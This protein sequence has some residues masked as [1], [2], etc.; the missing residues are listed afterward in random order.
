MIHIPGFTFPVEEFL[1]EDVVQMTRWAEIQQK[2]AAFKH[3]FS[4]NINRKGCVHLGIVLRRRTKGPGGKKAFG[5]G[6]ISGLRR[7]RKRRN[8]WKAGLVMHAP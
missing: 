1:L 8:T 2:I 6:K 7:R 4:T 3:K 5:R